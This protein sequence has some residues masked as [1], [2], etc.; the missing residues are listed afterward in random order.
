MNLTRENDMR[1]SK[2]ILLVTSAALLSAALLQ[3]C[4]KSREQEAAEAAAM[5]MAE[6]MKSSKAG[7]PQTPEQALKQGADAMAAAAGAMMSGGKGAV[8]P[9]D[10]RELQTLLPETIGGLKRGEVKGEKAGA[11]GIKVSNAE[12]AYSAGGDAR[13]TLKIVDSGSIS[14]FAGMAGA[15]WM[16]VDI[17]RE[18]SS[19]YEKTSTAAG[20]KTHEKWDKEGKHGEVNMVVAS[21]FIIEIR[22]DGIEMKDLKQAAAALDYK[23]LEGYANDAP[24]AAAK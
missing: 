22:G 9:M 3:G 20:R 17:D 21:R 8:E 7:A 24:V 23:K 4:G 1:A 6:A 16:M 11:M 14:G 15:A 13:I 10:F 5:K 12:A 2:Q 18:S 19:G